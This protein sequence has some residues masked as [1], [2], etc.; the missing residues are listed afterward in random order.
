MD[1]LIKNLNQK[2]AEKIA[3]SRPSQEIMPQGQSFAEVL[4]AKQQGHGELLETM[5]NEMKGNTADFN[6]QSGAHIEVNLASQDIEKTG[7]GV[8]SKVSD[9]FSSINE[10]MLA[11]DALF[12]AISDPKVKF[13]RRQLFAVQ[14]GIQHLSINTELFAKM[15]QAISTNIN[16][17]FNIQAGA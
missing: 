10:D 6:V 17:V 2:I 13:N 4:Q 16:T 7:L 9:L 11:F 8:E 1:T 5:V 3:N 15:V 14:A 12:E